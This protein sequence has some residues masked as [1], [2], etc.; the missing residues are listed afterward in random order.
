MVTDI[1]EESES[2]TST[3]NGEELNLLVGDWGREDLYEDANLSFG[4]DDQTHPAEN[5]KYK[6]K[7]EDLFFITKKTHTHIYINIYIYFLSSFIIFIF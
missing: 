4:I 5:K 6:W 3:G 1:I 2:S 7:L